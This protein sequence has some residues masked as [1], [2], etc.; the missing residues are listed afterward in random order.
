MSDTPMRPIAWANFLAAA[1]GKRFPVD[2]TMIALEY[3]QRFA[4]PIKAIQQAEIDSFE[5]ALFPLTKTGKWAILYNP[6]ITSPGR[7]NF[8]LAHELGHYLCHRQLNPAGF[9]CGEDRLLGLDRNA[10]RR[11]L[12]QEA[13]SFAS[14]L[15]MPI[16]DY[17]EQV[18]RQ[19]MTLDLLGH[20]AD[21]YQVSRTAAALKWLDFTAECAALVVATNGFVLWCW[22]SKLAKRRGIYFAR[23]APLPSASWAANPGLAADTKG[24]VLP[25]G[26]WRDGGE[27]RELSIFADRYEMTISLVMFGEEPANGGLKWSR[28]VSKPGVTC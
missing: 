4:D 13:D 11:T 6:T 3:S 18:G 7:I 20:M 10:V 25:E 21:R 23:G 8:T 27:A 26:V 15:L 9:E 1:W 19:D 14:Y 28:Q 16:D 24:L 12:E 17:R 5:G 22:R 2:V